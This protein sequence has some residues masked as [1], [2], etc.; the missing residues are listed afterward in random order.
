MA[1][2]DTLPAYLRPLMRGVT[3]QAPYCVVCGATSPLNQ[4]HVVRRGAGKMYLNGVEIRKP[5]LTLC[6]NGNASGC[7]GKAHAQTLHFRWVQ[8]SEPSGEGFVGKQVTV[9]AGHWE[10]METVEPLKEIKAQM[11]E[12]DSPKVKRWWE[13]VAG[14]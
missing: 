8:S 7:H 12:L 14:K 4:H 6:G 9:T 2:V 5:T 13:P 10:S 3:V 1:K 11:L